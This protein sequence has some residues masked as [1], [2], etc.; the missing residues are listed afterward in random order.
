MAHKRG[1]DRYR[2]LASRLFV[3]AVIMLAMISTSR[4]EAIFP[5]SGLFFLAGCVLVGMA[6]LGRLWCSLYIAGYKNQ[7]LITCGPYSLCRNPLYFF[8]MIGAVGVAL[9]SETLSLPLLV[10]IAFACYYPPVIRSEERKL[11]RLHPEAF[12]RYLQQTPRFWPRLAQPQEPDDY[13]VHPRLF[14]SHM[15]SACW[16]IW[17]VG[18]LEIIEYCHEAHVLPAWMSLY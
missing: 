5:V 6:T 16:F 11:A 13:T 14:R 8:S 10:A 3:A 7:A 18:G 15:L 9:C 12:A 4:W 1:F 2:M 17:L